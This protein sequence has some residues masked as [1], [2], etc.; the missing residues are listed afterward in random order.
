MGHA[1]EGTWLTQ[2]LARWIALEKT[3]ISISLLKES[4]KPKLKEQ[5]IITSSGQI[6]N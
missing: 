3:E 4:L 5:S 1:K 2:S 6:Y